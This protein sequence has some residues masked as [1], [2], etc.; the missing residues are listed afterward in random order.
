MKLIEKYKSNN[1]NERKKVKKVKYIVLHYTAMDNHFEAIDRLCSTKH[2]VSSHF[3]VSK[4]GNIYYLVDIRK[5]AWHAGE[6]YWQGTTDINSNSIGIELDNNGSET[7]NKKQINSL[8]FLLSNITRILKISKHNILG[9]S[10]ISPFRKIDP[11]PFFP[12]EFIS[13][14]KISY[15]P[16]IRKIQKKQI[17]LFNK[18]KHLYLKKSLINMEK[19]GYDTRGVKIYSKKYINLITAYQSHY[20]QGNINGKPD[21]NTLI[22]LEN[23]CK[24]LLTF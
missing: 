24:D 16:K 1:F 13:L 6:S 18:N 11:G 4:S 15:L 8:F 5:R 9:H 10:D 20:Y 21:I 23:H 7:Y 12:W 17:R 2:K 19:L 22:L 3:L 14:K